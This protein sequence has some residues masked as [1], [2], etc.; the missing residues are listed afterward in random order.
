MYRQTIDDAFEAMK[1][2]AETT[3][4]DKLR[5]L[6]ETYRVCKDKLRQ[7]DESKQL[8]TQFI[9]LHRVDTRKWFKSKVD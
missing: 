5:E 7:E 4:D 2:V 8:M 3:N 6:Y 1:R 9:D